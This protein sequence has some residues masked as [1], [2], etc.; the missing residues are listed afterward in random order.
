MDK[1]WF[2][3]GLIFVLAFPKLFLFTTAG[4]IAFFYYLF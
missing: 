1:I 4:V 3:I 2:L